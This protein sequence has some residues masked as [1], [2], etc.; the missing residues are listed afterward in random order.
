MRP[1]LLLISLT[2][3]M[4][5]W[6]A[7]GN[8]I[9][10][11][12]VTWVRCA[13]CHHLHTPYIKVGPSLKGIYGKK[14]TISGIPFQIWNQD[15]LTAWLNDPRAIKANTRMLLPKLSQRDRQDIIAWLKQ[16]SS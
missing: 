5:V 9:R 2:L 12:S 7:E 13:P 14:P 11:E 1:L 4:P 10:G 3:S 16:Q 15:T 8:A 6:A